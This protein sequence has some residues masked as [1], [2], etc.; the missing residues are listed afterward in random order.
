MSKW[1]QLNKTAL[2]EQIHFHFD[3]KW[4]FSFHLII[5][6]SFGR[7]VVTAHASRKTFSLQVR[8]TSICSLDCTGSDMFSLLC[9]SGHKFKSGYGSFSLGTQCV[10]SPP[11]LCTHLRAW[12]PSW[13]PMGAAGLAPQ[14]PSPCAQ[15]PWGNHPHGS[16]SIRAVAV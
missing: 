15:S 1:L 7:A 11:E 3:A 12:S 9:F 8:L 2:G 10:V 14:P 13:Q 6:T 5:C 16:Q 4:N